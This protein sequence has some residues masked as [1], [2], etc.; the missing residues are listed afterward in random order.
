MVD[1]PD[2]GDRTVVV[3]GAGRGL[4]RT[5]ARLFLARGATVVYLSRT[6]YADVRAEVDAAASRALFIR[7]DVS[8]SQ[9]VSKAFR[10][11]EERSERLDVLVN[12]AGVVGSGTLGETT[13]EAWDHVIANN[14]RSQFLCARAALPL[15]RRST[16]ARIINV[17]SVAGRDRSLLLGCAYTASKAAVIGL[18]RHLAAEL[19]PEGIRVNCVCPSQHRTP[20]LAAVLDEARERMLI[21]RIPLGYIPPAEEI[22]E[23]IAFLASH[24]ARYM[25]GAVVDVNGGLL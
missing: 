23:V 16:D 24:A 9:E 10:A 18:T 19:G 12:N 14:V 8:D 1:H 17:S 4:G 15:L 25:N 7:A 21:E 20:M 11:V 5:I 22:A 6:E 3:T 2:L 13:P